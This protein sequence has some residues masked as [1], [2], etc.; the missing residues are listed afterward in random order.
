MVK[1]YV[2]QLCKDYH[3][4]NL[5][6]TITMPSELQRLEWNGKWDWSSSYYHAIIL[7]KDCKMLV[8][9]IYGSQEDISN[10]LSS[11]DFDS[12]IF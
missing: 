12:Y 5:S 8:F 7:W 10:I 6:E 2:Q 4:E 3:R 1:K 9:R 11:L